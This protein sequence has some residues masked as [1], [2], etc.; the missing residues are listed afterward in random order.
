MAD[1]SKNH[2]AGGGGAQEQGTGTSQATAGNQ[3]SVRLRAEELI[4]RGL[5]LYAQGDLIG[6]L[7]EWRHALEIDRTNRRGRDYVTY[8]EDHFELLS[9]KFRVAREQRE[10]EAAAEAEAEPLGLAIEIEADDPM[11]DMSPYESIRARGV[12]RPG[13]ER[14]RGGRR[15]EHDAR[16]RRSARWR[17]RGRRQARSRAQ[18]LGP[19]GAGPRAR[20]M[21]DG[22]VVAVGVAQ[23]RHP[24][25]GG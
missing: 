4:E 8:V 19:A 17:R 21:A 20:R 25:D 24:G 11:E 18:G 3:S 14:G 7:A 12:A 2:S 23:Q 1:G 16:A 15:R 13:G 5:R 9:E 6:A 22:G 10:A